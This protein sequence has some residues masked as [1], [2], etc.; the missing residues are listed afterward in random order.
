LVLVACDHRPAPPQE[1]GLVPVAAATP[2]PPIAPGDD[3]C[4]QIAI[5][6]TEIIISATADP[7]QKA[8]YE[9]ERTK[10]VRRFAENCKTDKWPDATRSCFMAAKSPQDIE[11]CTRELAKSQPHSPPPA[12][13]GSAPVPPAGSGLKREN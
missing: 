2:G 5:K 1:K 4:M 3:G 9:Q 10:L 6:L 12:N 11:V 8:A 13:P 7:T